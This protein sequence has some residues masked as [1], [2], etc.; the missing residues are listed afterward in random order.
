M[1]KT[2]TSLSKKQ[3]ELLREFAKLEKGKLSNKLKTHAEG[4]LVERRQLSCQRPRRR[5]SKPDSGIEFEI[6]NKSEYQMTDIQ[7]RFD[8]SN[9]E[10]VSYFGIS[11]I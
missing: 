7:N 8:H 10:F 3:E 2:P 11:S 1:I 4:R 5:C 9:F 6:R